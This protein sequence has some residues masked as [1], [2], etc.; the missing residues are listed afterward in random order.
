MNESASHLSLYTN[1]ICLN[2]L[3]AILNQPLIY[4][5]QLK[6]ISQQYLWINPWQE[7]DLSVEP[8]ST[9]LPIFKIARLVPKPTK[10]GYHSMENKL[11]RTWC[12]ASYQI[13]PAWYPSLVGS[14]TLQSTRVHQT[15][16]PIWVFWEETDESALHCNFFS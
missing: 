4:P 16:V 5:A 11:K 9:N 3:G 14:S 15:R 2:L 6:A 10:L 8:Q 7:R 13:H 12:A 1:Y